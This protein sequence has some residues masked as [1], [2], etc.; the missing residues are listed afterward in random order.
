MHKVLCSV[1]YPSTRER[2]DEVVDWDNL[3]SRETLVAMTHCAI[4]EGGLVTL[5]NIDLPLGRVSPRKLSQL[6]E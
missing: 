3:A 2:Y 1:Y 5:R 4:S 6:G